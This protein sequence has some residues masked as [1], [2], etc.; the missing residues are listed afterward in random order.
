M[1]DLRDWNA[2]FMHW[3]YVNWQGAAS[4]PADISEESLFATP[5]DAM[6]QPM[7]KVC[8]TLSLTV[9]LHNVYWIVLELRLAMDSRASIAA[10]MKIA[11]VQ[12]KHTLLCSPQTK[13]VILLRITSLS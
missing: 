11:A 3:A 12:S 7:Q 2:Q 10:G 6:E 8:C 5:T 4:S 9:T 1:T 13:H